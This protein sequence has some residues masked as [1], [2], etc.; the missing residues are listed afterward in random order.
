MSL[1]EETEVKKLVSV[2]ATSTLMTRTREK[3]V[4]TLK[5]VK[6][7]EIGQDGKESKSEYPNLAQVL[8]IW[9]PIIIRKKTMSALLDLGSEVN[10]IHPTLAWELG[11][12]IRPTDVRAQKIDGTILDTFRMVATAFSLTDKGNRVKFFEESFL[13][14][15]VSP[16]VVL[17]MLFLTLSSADVDFLSRELRWRIYTTEEAFPTTRNI[18]LVGEKEFA[19]AAFDPEHETYVVYVG[20]VSSNTSSS[21]S[22]LNVHPF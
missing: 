8:C 1:E 10:I 15:N 18:K 2:L 11:L 5:A 22:P 3:V 14:A 16:D 20:S 4:E 21:S 12:S 13:V 6:N 19:A 7:V 17:G 9:Y